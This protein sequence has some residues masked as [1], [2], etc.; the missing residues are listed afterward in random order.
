MTFVQITPR[1]YVQAEQIT[2][3]R[4]GEGGETA[5]VYVNGQAQG[6]HIES[7]YL[8]NLTAILEA[9]LKPARKKQ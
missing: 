7:A 9:N 5:H 6:I 4:M 8:E 1:S 2:H 3:I